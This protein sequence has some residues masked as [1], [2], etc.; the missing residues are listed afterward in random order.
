MTVNNVES[1][2]HALE[3]MQRVGKGKQIVDGCRFYP[4]RYIN[5]DGS[6]VAMLFTDNQLDTAIRQA[7]SAVTLPFGVMIKDLEEKDEG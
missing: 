1:E 6:E 3:G 5:P 7:E 4:A 2:I